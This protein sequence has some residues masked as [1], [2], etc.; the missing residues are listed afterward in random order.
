[1]RKKKGPTAARSCFWSPCGAGAGEIGAGRRMPA[2]GAVFLAPLN[3]RQTEEKKI[4]VDTSLV[5]CAGRKVLKMQSKTPKGGG[6][7]EG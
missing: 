3:R 6:K 4:L 2:R 7:E 5:R 1:M